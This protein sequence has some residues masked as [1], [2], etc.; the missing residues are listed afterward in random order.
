MRRDD[1]RLIA[2]HLHRERT[3]IPDRN[4]VDRRRRDGISIEQLARDKRQAEHNAEHLRRAHLLR[5]RPADADR[6][7]VE[8][9]LADEP[10]ELVH[11]RP[12]RAD[13]DERLRSIL[14]KIERVDAVAETKNQTADDD[15]RDDWRENL[16]D[17]CDR[18]LE[19]VLIRLRGRLDRVLRHT[20]DACNRREI[21]VEHRDVVADDDLELAGLREAALDD[22]HRL[23]ALDVCFRGDV[24]LAADEPQKLLRVFR[25]LSHEFCSPCV[26]YEFNLV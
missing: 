11:A 17:D 2:D 26:M 20:L 5:D 10:E 6:Q 16:C 24:P 14:E 9:G 4:L 21:I 3:E 8:H 15:G 19:H 13:F 12:E 18:P 23:D 7:H 1:L 22:L 25:V